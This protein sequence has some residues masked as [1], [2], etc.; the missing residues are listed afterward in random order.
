[1]EKQISKLM[2]LLR[3]ELISQIAFVVLLVVLGELNVFAG[4]APFSP[5]TEFVL[6]CVVIVLTLVT[7]PIAIK[8]FDLNTTRNLRRM[9]YD[10]ALASYHL[11][12]IV[13]LFSLTA[14]CIMGVL[15]YYFTLNVSFILCACISMLAVILFCI[16]SR[17]KIEDYLERQGE[18]HDQ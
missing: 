1:M 17:H 8:L 7:I 13:R 5:N 2:T 18:E 14:P 3:A 15:F 10:E 9:N 16:P 6:E 4:N 11:W 12:S